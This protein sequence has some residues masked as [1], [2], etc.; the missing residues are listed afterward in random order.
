MA[1]SRDGFIAGEHDETPWSH[2]E[3]AEF[4]N[5]VKSCDVCIMGRRTYEL[6]KSDGFVAGPRYIVAT[7]KKDYDCGKFEA[8]NI[9]QPRDVPKEKTVGIIGGGDL[10]GSL[11]QLGL[12]DEIILDVEDIE[13]KNGK[14]LLGNNAVALHLEIISSR[15]ITDSLRQERYKVARSSGNS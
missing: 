4:Q 11:A 12:I 8:R 5:F 6:M 13:L 2:E 7:T 14:R 10:N 1:I 3:W 15:K 9:R